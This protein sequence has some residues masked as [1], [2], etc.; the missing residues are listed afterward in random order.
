MYTVQY[1]QVHVR[2]G[3]LLMKRKHREQTLRAQTQDVHDD[4]GKERTEPKRRTEGRKKERERG[5]I[6]VQYCIHLLLIS[7]S[8]S[9]SQFT[10][11]SPSTSSSLLS[12]WKLLLTMAYEWPTQSSFLWEVEWLL[13]H[14]LK[15]KLFLKSI[16]VMWIY[17]FFTIFPPSFIITSQMGKLAISLF[18]LVL[19]LQCPKKRIIEHRKPREL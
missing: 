12:K 7:H 2:R 19:S 17:I 8:F 14:N 15:S 9:W 10:F 16:T 18:F 1:K 11:P 3:S 6:H 4:D 13:K 5:T